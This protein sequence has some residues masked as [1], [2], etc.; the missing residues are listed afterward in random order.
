MIMCKTIP[1]LGRAMTNIRALLIVVGLAIGFATC[2][3]ADIFIVNGS[4]S[5][6]STIAGAVDIDPVLGTISIIALAVQDDPT[7]AYNQIFAQVDGGTS[8][9]EITTTAANPSTPPAVFLEILNPV[10]PGTLLGFTGGDLAIG[11]G[12]SF[13]LDSVGDQVPFTQ[14]S[15]NATPEPRF[16]AV[17]VIGLV[18]VGVFARRRRAGTSI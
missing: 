7:N 14:G 18:A 15:V 17:L 9:L 8:Y 16:C 12:G 3:S 1:S 2:A 11:G 6:S 4:L 10:D 5:D 13:Y